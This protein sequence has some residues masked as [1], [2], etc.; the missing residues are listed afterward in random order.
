MSP[1]AL[2]EILP[3]ETDCLADTLATLGRA[4]LGEQIR[5]VVIPPQV[6]SGLPDEFSLMAY[7]WPRLDYEARKAKDLRD[8]E[9]LKLPFETGLVTIDLDDFGEINWF[10][11]YELP[12]IFQIIDSAVRKASD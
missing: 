12:R 6:V 7:P 4:E 2:I 1:I 3:T 10:Y 8:C 5:R 9:R 11:V